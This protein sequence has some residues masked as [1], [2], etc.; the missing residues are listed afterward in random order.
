[1]FGYHNHY[2]GLVE[3]ISWSDLIYWRQFIK[4]MAFKTLIKLL[5]RLKIEPQGMFSL[6]KLVMSDYC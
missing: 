4:E 6:S 1:M 2:D 3:W 5:L